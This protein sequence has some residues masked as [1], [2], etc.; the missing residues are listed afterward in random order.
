MAENAT[1]LPTTSAGPA[2]ARRG[3]QIRKQ[4][5]TCLFVDFS[6]QLIS[7]HLKMK[8]PGKEIRRIG[9][10]PAIRH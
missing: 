6:L 10:F 8:L 1:E 2:D 7:D 9:E 5:W 4:K 3:R